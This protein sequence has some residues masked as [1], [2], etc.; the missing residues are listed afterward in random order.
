MV[1][2][3]VTKRRYH[4]IASKKNKELYGS[5]RIHFSESKIPLK[6]FLETNYNEL[7][8]TVPQNISLHQNIVESAEDY[9]YYQNNETERDNISVDQNNDIIQEREPELLVQKNDNKNNDIKWLKKWAVVNKIKRKALR[10]MLQW[11]HKR[12]SNIPTCTYKL[13]KTPR[14]KASTKKIGNGEYLHFG[15]KKITVELSKIVN[16]HSMARDKKVILNCAIHIDGISFSSSSRLTGW[17]ILFDIIELKTIIKPILLGIYAGYQQP[18]D[19]D[20]FLSDTCNDFANAQQGLQINDLLIIYKLKYCV[21]DTPARC[22]CTCTMNANALFGCPFCSQKGS[23]PLNSKSTQFSKKIVEPLRTDENYRSRT[24]LAHHQPSH[25]NVLCEFEKCSIQLNMIHSFPIDIMHVGDLGVTK[26]MLNIILKRGDSFGVRVSKETIKLINSEFLKLASKK[27]LEFVRAARDL[28]ENS[29]YFKATECR[30]FSNY[31]GI[32][33]MKHL[34][35]PMYQHF[36]KYC[37]AI[38]LFQDKSMSEWHLDTGQLLLESFVKDF[39]KFYGFHLSYVVHVLLHL[40]EFI[41]LYGPLYEFAAY[42]FENRLRFVKDDIRLKRNAVSQLFNRCSERGLIELE[43]KSETGLAFPAES[44]N[45]NYY[46]G[47][48]F[49]SYSFKVDEINCFASVMYNE[50]EIPVRIVGFFK[51]NNE[52]CVAYKCLENTY[53]NYF[54]IPINGKE[55]LATDFKILLCKENVA[56]NIEYCAVSSI[57]TKYLCFDE[58]EYLLLIPMLHNLY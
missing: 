58:D 18:E 55:L 38:R 35:K 41:Q 4:Q 33:V 8:E 26:K 32:M 15:L 29:K 10:E 17:T 47:Y 3:K 46:M 25:H 14:K 52:P 20:D 9:L 1:K 36:L 42:R 24:S 53:K 39:K 31:Y 48:N 54:T 37:L 23:R 56:S 12:D 49:T 28:E 34:P 30:S 44:T 22:K 57:T 21:C 11:L 43:D 45:F 16:L 13:L 51:K 5:P 40:K 27:P 6:D 50:Q 7:F 2:I 19:F